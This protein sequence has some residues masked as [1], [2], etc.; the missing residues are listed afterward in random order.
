MARIARIAAG[1]VGT[2]I[3]GC[4]VHAAIMASGGYDATG[5]PLTIGLACGL[6][7]GAVVLGMC[8]RDRRYTLAILIVLGLV[9]GEGYA[10]IVTAER[11]LAYRETK[12]APLRLAA[13]TRA[14]AAQRLA[15]AELALA[16]TADTP[17]LTRALAAKREADAAVVGK[18]AERGCASHCRALLEQQVAI[19]QQEINAARAEVDKARAAAERDAAEAREGFA[20]LPVPGSASPLADRIG[21]ADWK[22]DLTAAALASI[23]ANGLGAFLIA[24][25]AHGRRREPVRVI[26]A[27][28]V[29]VETTELIE[30][31]QPEKATRD[32]DAEANKFA[33]AVFRPNPSGRISVA[34]IRTAYHQW[35]R[36]RGLPPLSDREIGASLNALFWKVGLQRDGS[37]PQTAILGIGWSDKGPGIVLAA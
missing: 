27:K 31:A 22:I 13:E 1:I 3:I 33:S 16:R 12:Q 32:A 37:G 2:G 29:E 25:A 15:D 36:E 14:K 4:V 23:S 34:D 28:A 5:S 19:A 10:L 35:C 17:R 8:W 20:A 30:T 18:A 9:A 21:V 26:A 7:A 6:V 11:T 24:F